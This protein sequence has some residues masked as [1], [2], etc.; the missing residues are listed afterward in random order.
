MKG[1]VKEGVGGVGV[2]WGRS[3]R[4][5]SEAMRGFSEDVGIVGAARGVTDGCAGGGI[6]EVCGGGVDCPRFDV[7]LMRSARVPGFSNCCK[8]GGILGWGAGRATTSGVL[9]PVVMGGVVISGT[10]CGACGTGG[11]L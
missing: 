4:A 10:I 11:G 2:I 7:A 6:R 3:P 1:S 9:C 5:R 8:L